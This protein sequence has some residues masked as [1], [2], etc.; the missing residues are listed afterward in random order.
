MK[1]SIKDVFLKELKVHKDQRG[2]LFEILRSDDKFFNA[3]GQA[4]ITVCNPGWV[5]GWHFHKK[6]T[7]Y[8]CVISGKARVVLYDVREN[9]P[10]KNVLSEYILGDKKP[11]LLKIPKGI[12]HGFEAVGKNPVWI[13]NIP[14]KIYN[15]KKPDEF[16]LNLNSEKISYKPWIKRKG[17]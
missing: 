8:F 4:Y 12:I 9:S 3:F 7:D 17:W 6:Q 14:D 15:R 5:K 11:A 10:T 1:K 13:L 2:M 16:R